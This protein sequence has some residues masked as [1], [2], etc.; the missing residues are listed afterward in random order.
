[1]H[2]AFQI[3]LVGVGG[4][5]LTFVVVYVIQGLADEVDPWTN[6]SAWAEALIEELPKH[7][8]Y[9]VAHPILLMRAGL[10]LKLWE[11]H[12]P[13]PFRPPD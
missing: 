9:A 11:S 7:V 13:S 2:P 4:L 6:W 10:R 1:M 3:L 5:W 8:W 12:K